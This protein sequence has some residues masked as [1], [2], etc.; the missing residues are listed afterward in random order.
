MAA[1]I[2]F[3]RTTAQSV[4]PGRRS[5]GQHLNTARR[6]AHRPPDRPRSQWAQVDVIAEL[7]ELAVAQVAADDREFKVIVG[8]PSQSDVAD[9]VL[10]N[11]KAKGWKVLGIAAD[12]IELPVLSEVEG[13]LQVKLIARTFTFPGNPAP[14]EGP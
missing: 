10:G 2:S 11:L 8:M 4:A 3:V 13:R 6:P 5:R 9:D 1:A 7:I 12:Q 14:A